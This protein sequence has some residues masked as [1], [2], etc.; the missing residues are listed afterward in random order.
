MK[1]NYFKI[2]AGG[3]TAILI[4]SAL[5][6]C[7]NEDY[8]LDKEFNGDIVILKDISL[9]IGNLSKISVGDI[10]SLNDTDHMIVKESNGD[11]TFKFAG[12][13]PFSANFKV[14]AF[15]VPFEEGTKADD[16]YISIKTGSLSGTSGPSVDK[17]LRLENQRLEKVITVNDSY[18]LPYQITDIKRIDTGIIVDYNFSTTV[19]AMYIAQGFQ[20]DFPDWIIIEK[21]DDHNDY[22]VENQGD[23]ENIVRFLNDVRVAADSPYVLE[24][25]IKTIHLP[26]GS[27]I[28]GGNDA[29]GRACKKV[30]IDEENPA[31]MIIASGDVF[32]QTKDFPTVP[33]KADLKLHLEL[34]EFDVKSA[35]LQL[36]MSTVVADQKVP[37]VEYP[38]FFNNEG[39][40]IDL[41]NPAL[42]FTADNKLPVA[43]DFN[44]TILAYKNSELK[45]NSPIADFLIAPSAI[46]AKTFSALG[47]NQGNGKL[48]ILKDIIKAMPDDIT[49]SDIT[50]ST[51]DDYADIAPGHILNCSMEYELCA[52][53]AFGTDFRLD[54]AMDIENVGA[55]LKDLGLKSA[56]L[57]MKVENSIP[58]NFSLQ[59]QALDVNGNVIEDISV[60]VDGQIAPGIQS[61]PTVSDVSIELTT[62]NETVEFQSLKLNL[63]ATCPTAK[64]QGVALNQEQGLKISSVAIH[65]PSGLAL[66]LDDLL[67]D[68]TPENN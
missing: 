24:L 60:S 55:S 58:L 50:V 10:I 19:G 53:L 36:N 6:S 38:E 16:H 34:S 32:L 3:I 11:Y 59:T 14:P 7:I 27:I 61:A 5:N 2:F 30:H 15:S 49:V 33:D 52:P 29:Q 47:D 41:H 62:S 44:A 45:V 37:V 65:L 1:T 48:P 67:E 43:L 31:N 4:S 56:H 22:V 51:T 68:P 54:Y 35:N 63:T 12:I 9:P 40:V 8:S 20:I 18:L 21:H 66:E 26:E 64:Y 17:Q 39:I 13:K 46:T 23:N 42:T 28:A 25:V 57:V